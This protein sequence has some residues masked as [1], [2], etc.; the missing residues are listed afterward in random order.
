M[1]LLPATIEPMISQAVA[2]NSVIAEMYLRMT[3]AVIYRY[4][5]NDAQAIRHIDRAIA[6]ALPDK[7]YGFLAEYCRTN[8]Y[9]SR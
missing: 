4:S 1:G 8:Y 9:L 6:L 7:C 3:C 5:G 2:D